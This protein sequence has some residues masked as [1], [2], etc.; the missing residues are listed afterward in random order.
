MRSRRSSARSIA[1]SSVACSIGHYAGRCDG[2][3]AGYWRMGH[4][5]PSPSPTEF[6]RFQTGSLGRHRQT[7]HR[8]GLHG[9]RAG[10]QHLFRT[11][12]GHMTVSTAIAVSPHCGSGH[13]HALLTMQYC[14]AGGSGVK[15]R[16]ICSGRKLPIR[17]IPEPVNKHGYRKGCRCIRGAWPGPADSDIKQGIHRMVEFPLRPWRQ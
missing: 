4:N 12:V 13:C 9:T 3:S 6:S 15:R 7:P 1:D 8:N 2:N 11:Q 5:S 14:L 10:R 17:R 16:G